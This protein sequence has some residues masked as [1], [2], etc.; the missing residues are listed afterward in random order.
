MQNI[1]KGSR[2]KRV[3]GPR[4]YG[5]L[6]P[7]ALKVVYV[8]LGEEIHENKIWYRCIT[9]EALASVKRGDVDPDWGRPKTLKG[10]STIFLSEEVTPV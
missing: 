3:Q 8:V 4:R 9:P 2:V 5:V 7:A 6:T 10:E 1:I